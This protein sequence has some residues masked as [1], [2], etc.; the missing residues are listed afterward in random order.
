MTIVMKKPTYPP[1][2]CIVCGLG[3]KPRKW[4]V[5]LEFQL[6]THFNPVLNGAVYLCNECW[7]NLVET[8]GRE[9]ERSKLDDNGTGTD[10]GRL[11]IQPNAESY[12][13]PTINSNTT[14][15]SN[16]TP[17]PSDSVSESDVAIEDKSLSAFRGFF[18]SRA[19][20]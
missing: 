9:I 8:V 14:E 12:S 6:D 18:G 11:H 5:D 20:V 7:V 2:V 13:D 1:Y 10:E 3:D 15:R 19:S 4:F 16:S 17:S